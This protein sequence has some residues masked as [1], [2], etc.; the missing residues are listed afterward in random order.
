MCVLRGLTAVSVWQAFKV[1]V[2]LYSPNAVRSPSSSLL[3]LSPSLPLS[4]SR[5][6]AL[7]PCLSPSL[8]P[9]LFPFLSR[10]ALQASQTLFVHAYGVMQRKERTA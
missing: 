5:A 7:S 1:E 10:Y 2:A 8:P 4:L 9:S 6:L 3:S